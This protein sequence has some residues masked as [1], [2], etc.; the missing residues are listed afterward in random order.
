MTDHLIPYAHA[1]INKTGN[2]LVCRDKKTGDAIS[3]SDI[4]E[5]DVALIGHKFS[6]A[7]G[8]FSVSHLGI[9]KYERDKSGQI[10]K[11]K[12]GEPLIYILHANSTGRYGQE[13]E[14]VTTGLR[15]YLAQ[16]AGDEKRTAENKA[17][18][19]EVLIC[20]IKPESQ[21]LN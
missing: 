7:E 1:S 6:K 8:G 21:K 10:L 12:D 3:K 5:G 15:T 2:Q 17:R 16:R 18:Y 19:A 11:G 20:K 4:K 13:R 14:V 9:V